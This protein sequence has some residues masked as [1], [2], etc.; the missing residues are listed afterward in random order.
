MKLLVSGGTAEQRANVRSIAQFCATKLMTRRLADTLTVKIK[1]K[2]QMMGIEGSY[3][4]V[5]DDDFLPRPKKF[6]MRVDSDMLMR[7]LLTTVAHE[8][9]HVKQYARNEMREVMKSG[10]VMNRFNGSYYPLSQDYWEQPWEIEAMGWERG[11]F[12]MWAEKQGLYKD[13]SCKWVHDAHVNYP[14]GYWDKF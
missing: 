3:G 1:L 12:E 11:L 8:M 7:P 14:K 10:T 4:D 9:V 13:K 5:I 2:K 6:T